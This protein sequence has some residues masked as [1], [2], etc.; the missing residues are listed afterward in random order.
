MKKLVIALLALGVPIV[1]L[2]SAAVEGQVVKK[3]AGPGVKQ[4][5]AVIH[6]FG[7]SPAKGV[8]RFTVTDE[9]VEISGEVSGLKPGKHGFHIHE[10]GDCSSGDP[11]CH[12][13]HFNPDKQK[14][15]GPEDAERHVGD[16]GNISANGRGIAVIHMRDKQIALSGPRSIIGRAVIIHAKADDLKSQ[17]SGDAG[18]R[19]A[20]G[21]VGIAG[22]MADHKK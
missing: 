13:G 4:A 19:I 2:S 20:G 15:G 8:V 1:L 7:E 21:V 11:K 3:M 12:G 17:P 18:D 22:S 5:V 14:H 16:L 6:G 10:F 9:G